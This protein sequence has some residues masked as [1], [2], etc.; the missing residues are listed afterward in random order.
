VNGVRQNHA[1]FYKLTPAGC[2]QLNIEEKNWQ[3]FAFAIGKV[4]GA[5]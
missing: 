5:A 2:K 1:R 3:R 4:L